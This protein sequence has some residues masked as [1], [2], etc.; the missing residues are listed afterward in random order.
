MCENEQSLCT[1][2]TYNISDVVND[3]ALVLCINAL[4]LFLSLTL[5][6]PR[7]FGCVFA[8]RQKLLGL[9]IKIFKK[10]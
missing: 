3:S 2:I 4:H 6:F 9:Y 8:R 1:K 7:S 5:S 10:H